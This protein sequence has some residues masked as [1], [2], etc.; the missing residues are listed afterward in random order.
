MV[1]TEIVADFQGAVKWIR[2][3]MKENNSK[4]IPTHLNSNLNGKEW[5]WN[6]KFPNLNQTTDQIHPQPNLISEKM[7]DFQ[8]M[9]HP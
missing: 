8:K 6:L 4:N 7:A 5:I 2:I 1:G 3:Q 9:L